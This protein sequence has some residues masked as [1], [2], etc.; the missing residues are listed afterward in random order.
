MIKNS[1]EDYCKCE[2]SSPY[3]VIGEW[4]YCYFCSNCEKEIEDTFHYY[5][6]YDGEDHDDVELYGY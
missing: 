4:G 1:N 5:N 6:H 2:C 3:T